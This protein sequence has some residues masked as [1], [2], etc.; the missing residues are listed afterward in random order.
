[1]KNEDLINAV[2]KIDDSVIE[3]VSLTRKKRKKQKSLWVKITAVAACVCLLISGVWFGLDFGS[4]TS[5]SAYAIETAKYPETAQYPQNISD[6]NYEQYENSYDSW[7]NDVRARADLIEGHEKSIYS[8]VREALPAFLTDEKL[9]DKNIVFSPLNVYM[10]LS[11]LAES[12][13]GES[14][15]Q[16]LELLGVDNIEK[17]RESVSAVWNSTYRDD[18]SVKRLLSN[19]VWLSEELE[20]NKETMKLLAEKYYTSS[21][22]GKMGS[23][24]YNKELQKWLSEETGGLLDDYAAEEEFSA[25]TVLALA[26]TVF[27]SG[28]WDVEFSKSETALDIFHGADGDKEAEFMKAQAED[29]YFYSDNFSAYRRYFKNQAGSMYFIL[30]DEGVSVNEVLSDSAALKLISGEKEPSGKYLKINL[31]V[32]KFDISSRLDLREGVK[33]LGITDVFDDG[34]SDFSPMFSGDITGIYVDKI[35]HSARIKID[36]EGCEAAAFTTIM[37]AGKGGPPDETVD[38]VLDRPFIVCISDNNGLPIFVGV[39]NNV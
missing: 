1:M 23:D 37:E 4:E 17:L 34:K 10:A 3:D 21:F 19:S 20:Y 29:Y 15:Q 8:F 35:N 11:L 26:S 28:K 9:K 25:Q 13:D 14:R 36:E 24:E 39:V 33:K 6:D 38:F 18:G 32:P 30:P 5:L 27:F 2:G 16:I 12:T 31:S 22:K 7:F